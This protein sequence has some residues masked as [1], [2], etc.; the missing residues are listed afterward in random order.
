MR[1]HVYA[2]GFEI[3]DL[4]EI[5]NPMF[6]EGVNPMRAIRSVFRHRVCKNNKDDF[7][8]IVKN[9]VYDS[10]EGKHICFGIKSYYKIL[11]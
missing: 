6:L 11:Y 2:V 9:A 3:N 10:L 5:D 1:G 7:N 4:G 8:F